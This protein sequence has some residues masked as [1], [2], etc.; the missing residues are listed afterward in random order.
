MEQIKEVIAGLTPTQIVINIAAAVLLV[1]WI[2]QGI[3]RKAKKKRAK[4]NK[5][6]DPTK[7]YGYHV[8]NPQSVRVSEP[9]KDDYDG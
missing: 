7:G 5:D 6:F 1:I 4:I 9:L 8:R 3:V 2:I